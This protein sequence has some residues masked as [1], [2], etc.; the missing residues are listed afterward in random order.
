M[1]ERVL[2]TGANGKLGRPLVEAL[3]LAG[4]EVCALDCAPMPEQEGVL[5][6]LADVRD[7][8]AHEHILRFHPEIVVHL[9]ANTDIALS[10]AHPEE[11]ARVNMLG[12]LNVLHAA[13]TAGTKRFVLA[14]SDAVR[15][16]AA[17]GGVPEPES[18]YGVSKLAAE[19][20][21]GSYRVIYGLPFA[22]L[23]LPE[24][25]N[26]EHAKTALI[27]AIRGEYEGVIDL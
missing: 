10:H 16:K 14:S 5:T 24:G 22:A 1:A 15:G 3:V 2:I 25:G 20:Y 9:A 4:Y 8:S 13:K 18:P 23:R 11:D 19:R 12:S 27:R 21:C 6:I 17:P 7:E 26:E